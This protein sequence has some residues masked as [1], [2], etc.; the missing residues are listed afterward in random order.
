[1]KAQTS[2]SCKRPRN[3]SFTVSAVLL[4]AIII[5]LLAPLGGCSK[6]NEANDS[7]PEITLQNLQTAY[8]REM[9]I[10]REYALFSRKAEKDR[11]SAIANLYRATSRSEEIHAEM[12]AVLL[13]S[14]GIEVKPYSP[15]SIIV[16]TVMQTLRLA[17]SDEGLETESMYPNLARTADL[18][19]FPEAAESFRRTLNADK[20]HV[21]LFKDAL[22]K[23]G[24]IVKVQYYVCPTCGYIITSEKIEECPGCH[25]K[26]DKFEKI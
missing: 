17:T 1:M 12:A 14:K 19:K 9:R 8:S 21:E 24:T 18:E 20:R 16:G 10:G 7:K 5:L 15:D 4:S 6:K 3:F 26:K 23:G 2:P 25:A 22:D 13:R 11:F